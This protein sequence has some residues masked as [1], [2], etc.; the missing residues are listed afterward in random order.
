V[1][2]LSREEARRKKKLLGKRKEKRA[3]QPEKSGRGGR[4]TAGNDYF[5]GSRC[6]SL[7][8]QQAASPSREGELRQKEREQ[9]LRRKRRKKG[10]ERVQVYGSGAQ[11]LSSQP[12]R[13]HAEHQASRKERVRNKKR[14]GLEREKKKETI[15]DEKGGGKLLKRGGIFPRGGGVLSDFKKL[16]VN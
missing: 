10:G 1:K 5:V 16:R 12:F 4:K 7:Q 13:S 11:L 14:R 15:S 2:G 8:A 3:H 9:N 6:W